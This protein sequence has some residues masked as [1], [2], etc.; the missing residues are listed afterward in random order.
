M[1]LFDS[2]IWTV[3][4]YGVEVWGWKKKESMEKLEERYLRWIQGVDKVTP[5]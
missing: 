1:W 5:G 3:M 2:L 4:S